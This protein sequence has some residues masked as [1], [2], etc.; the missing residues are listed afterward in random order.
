MRFAALSI[1]A[2]LLLASTAIAGIGPG[3][4]ETGFGGMIHLSPEP[5]SIDANMHLVY[6]VNPAIGFGPYWMVSKIGDQEVENT[7][8]DYTIKHATH[9]ALGGLVKVYLPLALGMMEPGG[10]MPFVEGGFGIRTLDK[11][12]SEYMPTQMDDVEEET[13]TK[14]ELI[15]RL[16]F[17]YWMTKN[18]SLW[19]AY[20]GSKILADEEDFGQQVTDFRSDIRIGIATFL[21]R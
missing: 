12:G 1:I 13:E 19:V 18:W 9:Y 21:M 5:W 8:Y 15:I 3:T 10:M 16:G 11:P 20:H 17:D 4:V 7:G 6:Y 2:M 14:P